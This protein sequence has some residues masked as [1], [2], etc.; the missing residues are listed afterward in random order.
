DE[1][2]LPQ[3]PAAVRVERVHAVVR[4]AD[5]HDVVRAARSGD[6]GQIQRLR[7]DEAVHWNREQLAELCRVDV[8]RREGGLRQIL[9]RTETVVVILRHVDLRGG[10]RRPQEKCDAKN[11]KGNTSP[12][13]DAR[14][15]SP[16]CRRVAETPAHALL[17]GAPL[18]GSP[19]KTAPQLQ[20]SIRS[21]VA[22]FPEGYQ[23]N[24][25]AGLL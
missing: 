8:Q 3:E 18:A 9:T 21:A 6:A 16:G 25:N 15:Q 12:E 24:P 4:R 1:A 5:V 20:P 2:P 19:Q 10:L 17:L 23:V 14:W 13:E 11:K 7:V 22:M